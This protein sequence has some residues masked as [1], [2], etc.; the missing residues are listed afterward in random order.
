MTFLH[1]LFADAPA[2]ATELASDEES[3]HA[4]LESLLEHFSEKQRILARLLDGESVYLHLHLLETALS[5]ELDIVEKETREEREILDDLKFLS[6]EGYLRRLGELRPDA[7][8]LLG[9]L[10]DILA[11]QARKV[12]RLSLAQGD[13]TTVDALINLLLIERDIAEKLSTRDDLRELFRNLSIGVR[14][15]SAVQRI[16]ERFSSNLL[17]RLQAITID[18]D[19]TARSTDGSYISDL[20][21]RAFNHLQDGIAEAVES[22]AIAGHARADAE[23]IAS[24]WFDRFVRAEVREDAALGKAVPSERTIGMF[25]EAFRRIYLAEDAR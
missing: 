12:R 18:Q 3:V 19:G 2:I 21:A 17:A 11:A 25:I 7:Y 5:A 13:A 9:E 6:R 4:E 24:E 20:C 16:R 15:G 14:R 23:F 22:G 1:T 10:R 8:P